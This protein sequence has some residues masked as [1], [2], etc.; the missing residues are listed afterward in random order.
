[1]SGDEFS[2]SLLPRRTSSSS[3]R[4]SFRLPMFSKAG[5]LLRYENQ[6][7]FNRI[8]TKIKLCT[9][10]S[11]G[12][13]DV[14]ANQQCSQAIQ[15]IISSH[16]DSDE[17]LTELIFYFSKK[18]PRRN[19][20]TDYLL[21]YLLQTLVVDCGEPFHHAMNSEMLMRS[22][23]K[24]MHLYRCTKD[25][26]GLQCYLLASDMLKRWEATFFARRKEFN[27]IIAA[28]QRMKT[29]F[30]SKTTDGNTYALPAPQPTRA[31]STSDST[32]RPLSMNAASL[33]PSS[34]GVASA[35]RRESATVLSSGKAIT[36]RKP[37]GT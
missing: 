1:M 6:E 22:M 30:T 31:T 28:C 7:V 32:P 36:P 5:A 15:S 11:L 12:A 26:K 19:P 27:H 14:H 16:P 33:R 10:E 23:E 13:P 3:Q 18:I 29:L 2:P 8:K 17:I 20:V 4:I 9:M 25:E 35:A 24:L 21:L 34:Y 37:L